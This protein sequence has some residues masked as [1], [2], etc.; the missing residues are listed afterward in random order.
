[1]PINDNNNNRR[2]YGDTNIPLRLISAVDMSVTLKFSIDQVQHLIMQARDHINCLKATNQEGDNEI[3]Q[4]NISILNEIELQLG[5]LISTVE[6][7]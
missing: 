6:G 4:V 3:I 5:L 2:T 1:M 7:L